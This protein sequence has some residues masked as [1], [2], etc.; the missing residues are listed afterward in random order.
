MALKWSL[1][2]T[3]GLK[4]G[5]IY[6]LKMESAISGLF[7][8][9]LQL[10]RRRISFVTP[11]LLCNYILTEPLCGNVEAILTNTCNAVT[12]YNPLLRMPLFVSQTRNLHFFLLEYGQ[13]IAPDVSQRTNLFGCAFGSINWNW[14]TKTL[15]SICRIQLNTCSW[16]LR[17]TLIG[18]IKILIRRQSLDLMEIDFEHNYTIAMC[19][20]ER[21]EKKGTFSW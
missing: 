4:S 6:L 10:L 9:I 8:V 18:P 14:T 7:F 16:W 5:K 3:N 15:S 11:I 20:K 19:R 2:E 17:S 12:F 1:N 21:K 13:W